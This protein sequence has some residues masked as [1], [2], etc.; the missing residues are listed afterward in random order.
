[1]GNARISLTT[2]PQVTDMSVR[3]LPALKHPTGIECPEIFVVDFYLS[4]K[5][6]F[7][8]ELERAEAF[9]LGHALVEKLTERP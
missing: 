5:A 8:V 7:S 1:M 4:D 9:N 6:L 2:Y 3:R